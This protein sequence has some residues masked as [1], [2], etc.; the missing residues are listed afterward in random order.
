M[1]PLS[2]GASISLGY[3]EMFIICGME[4]V[5]QVVSSYWF[6]DWYFI[7]GAHM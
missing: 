4:E 3:S 2:I 5:V 6:C 7:E 1:V